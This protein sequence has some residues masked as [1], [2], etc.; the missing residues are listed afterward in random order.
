MHKLDNLHFCCLDAS[1]PAHIL[2]TGELSEESELQWQ[3][4]CRNKLLANPCQTYQT[5][6]TCCAGQPSAWWAHLALE[7]K[8]FCKTILRLCSY[9]SLAILSWCMHSVLAANISGAP[10]GLNVRKTLIPTDRINLQSAQ[11]AGAPNDRMHH[12]E[13]MLLTWAAA[14]VKTNADVNKCRSTVVLWRP[15]TNNKHPAVFMWEKIWQNV[16]LSFHSFL[17]NNKKTTWAGI[18]HLLPHYILKTYFIFYHFLSLSLFL[19][20]S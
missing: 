15:K 12:R 10:C 5:S 9:I 1:Q 4:R 14:T 19:C 17:I 18:V 8:D 6:V 2:E 11:Q 3:R 13:V 7:M 20:L 16:S